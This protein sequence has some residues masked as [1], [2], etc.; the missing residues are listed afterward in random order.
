MSGLVFEH[1]YLND[2]MAMVEETE[3]PRIFHVW[4]AL[5][6]MAASLGRRCY[7][8]F[9]TGEI[10]PNMYVLLVGTPGTR[11]STAMSIAKRQIKSATHLRFAPADTGGQRQ[12]LVSAM[13]GKAGQEAEFLEQVQLTG[14][15][16]SLMGL[17]LSEVQEITNDV[18]EEVAIHSADKFHMMVATG[19]ITE[20]LGQSNTSMLGFLVKMWDG[21]DYEY[22]LKS[23]YVE[24]KNPLLDILGCSTP[25]SMALSL[26]PAAGGQ[27]FLS[28]CILVYGARKYKSVPRPKAPAE[29]LVLAV[30]DSIQR[31][32]Y[33]LDGAFDETPDALSYSESI[34]DFGLDIT[35]SRFG[36]YNERRYT[37]LIKLSM[38]LA[39]SRGT[40][41]IEK[42][43]VEQAHRI[44][45]A[46]EIGMPDALGEFGMNPLAVL[47]QQILESLRTSVS[48]TLDM[49]Q[50]QFH[51]DASPSDI[52]T[53]VRELQR[54]N[55]VVLA[56][57]KDGRVSVSAV[58][59]KIDTEDNM[60]KLLTA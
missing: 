22:G 33:D 43:D 23:S 40:K 42:I 7:F 37:H 25:T 31:A 34:Y 56:Q 19:E 55:Q 50:A 53:T 46:T 11:K 13:I 5:S 52:L 44:L 3:S 14:R 51:R 35:D 58:Y 57:G 54:V 17:T 39:A 36:Y 38:A 29:S 18:P 27:G 2:Y 24:L 45:R 12:G 41:L 49:L 8:P 10:F 20:L 30:R 4:G 28:R 60:M 15:D 47:K 16:D 9:G 48:T 21:E 59:N 1:Q 32:Y 26:P 6:A